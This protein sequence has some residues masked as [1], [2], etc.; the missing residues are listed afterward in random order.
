M[1]LPQ[2]TGEASL[3]RSSNRYHMAAPVGVL[4]QGVAIPQ[5]TPFSLALS[6]VAQWAPI[7]PEMC[8]C[9]PRAGCFCCSRGGCYPVAQ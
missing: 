9:L 1:A 7:E 5:L 6:E 3:Y 2:F 4:A 8:L